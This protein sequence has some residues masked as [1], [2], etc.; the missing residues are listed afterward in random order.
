MSTQSG[1]KGSS[2]PQ[3]VLQTIKRSGT[4]IACSRDVHTSGFFPE[5]KSG[6]I[7]VLGDVVKII[8]DDG[9]ND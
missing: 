3:R 9:P 7:P 6:L 4:N 8:G 1:N 5:I 2:S